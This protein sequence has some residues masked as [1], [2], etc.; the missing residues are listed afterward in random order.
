MMS[1]LKSHGVVLVVDDS[2][3]SL[4]LLNEALVS[5][6]YTIFIAM[7]GLQAV[8]IAERMEPDVIIMDAIMPNMDGFEACRQIK[9]NRELKDVPVIFMTGLSDSE[10]VVRGLK[11]GGVDY[12][13]KPVNIDELIARV[14]VHLQNSRQ[15]R[16]A[17]RAL[18]EIGQ[19][20]F[21]CDA[22]G[23]FLWCTSSARMFISKSA[24]DTAALES[25]LPEQIKPWLTRNPEKNSCLNIK[26]LGSSL[27]IR[28]IGK[29]S[30]DE[31]LLR[32]VQEGEEEI[33]AV[34]REQY[35][36]TERETEV[37]YWIAQGKANRDI[38]QILNM[39]PRTVNKHLE[40]I[41]RKLDVDNRTSAAT[42]YLQHL[43]PV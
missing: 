20:A 14:H 6:G 3:D 22:N 42:V 26:G 7:D 10:D 17:R 28:F 35:Q 4:E 12:I 33:R 25:L 37:L 18:D 19:N 5:E 32:F 31:F 11:A 8:T 9:K 41:Y 21:A 40:Q 16:S 43:N 27:K 13:N 38:A 29:S 1:Q 15:T 34:L 36:L 23:Q 30:P 2:A 24:L 39:S